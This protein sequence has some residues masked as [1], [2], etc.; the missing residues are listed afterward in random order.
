[1]SFKEIM[2]ADIRDYY[3]EGFKTRV[4]RITKLQ[5]YISNYIQHLKADLAETLE[6]EECKI[7]ISVFYVKEGL[8]AEIKIEEICLKFHRVRKSRDHIVVTGSKIITNEYPPNMQSKNT[9][10]L[11]KSWIAN[12][13]V[14]LSTF[15]LDKLEEFPQNIDERLDDYL[16][17]TFGTGE[18]DCIWH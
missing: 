1:M 2:I 13:Y 18:V 12:F 14:Y 9:K 5:E 16:K 8:F 4:G 3:R 17:K 7:E 11:G 10:L 15:N 6:N